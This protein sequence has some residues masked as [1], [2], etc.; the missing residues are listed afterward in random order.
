ML[1]DQRFYLFPY[2][3]EALH[4]WKQRNGS[5]ATYSKLIEIFK[6]AGYRNYADELRTL[7]QL[8]DSEGDDTS[9]S[10]EEHSQMEQ[11]QT[12]PAQKPQA[13]SQVPPATAESTEVYVEMEGK[14]NL[15]A[16]KNVL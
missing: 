2:R 6:R 14:E 1:L 9:S 5:K 15:Q 13:L 16:G 8:S 11:P 3:R 7:V 12:Y 10:G 4:T